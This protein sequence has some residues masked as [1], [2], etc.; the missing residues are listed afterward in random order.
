MLFIYIFFAPIRENAPFIRALGEED[1]IVNILLGVV[2][3]IGMGGKQDGPTL[4]RAWQILQLQYEFCM[5]RFSSA[6]PLFGYECEESIP[7]VC[8]CVCVCACPMNTGTSL[9]CIC[10]LI[11]VCVEQ[12]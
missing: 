8:V 10:K 11:M 3:F 9:Y 5:N 12:M 1:G 7:N 6:G 4:C 2:C